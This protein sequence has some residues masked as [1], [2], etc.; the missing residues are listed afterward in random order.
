MPVVEKGLIMLDMVYY[1]TPAGRLS[2]DVSNH[3]RSNIFHD[4][5]NGDLNPER[6]PA[7]N[8]PV[9]FSPLG[10]CAPA[11]LVVFMFTHLLFAPFDYASHDLTSFILLLTLH[12]FHKG[13]KLQSHGR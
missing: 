9:L 11:E 7:E 8:Y 5:M 6:D 10:P 2:L 4:H 1:N 13:F 12:C 3:Y